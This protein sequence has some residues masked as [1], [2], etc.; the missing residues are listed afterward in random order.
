MRLI[1]DF[2]ARVVYSLPFLFQ[3]QIEAFKQARTSK[4]TLKDNIGA[5]Y[6]NI[7]VLKVTKYVFIL[8]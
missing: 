1:F 2:R 3:G 5:V 8:F 6:K 7:N 4:Q